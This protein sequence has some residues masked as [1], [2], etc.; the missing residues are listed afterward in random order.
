MEHSAEQVHQWV[1]WDEEPPIS[2]D[3]D[4]PHHFVRGAELYYQQ[5]TIAKLGHFLLKEKSPLPVEDYPL[6]KFAS[7]K[8]EDELDLDVLKR[9]IHLLVYHKY[10]QGVDHVRQYPLTE[11]ERKVLEK[12]EILNSMIIDNETLYREYT[13]DE[14]ES[15]RNYS[16][17]LDVMAHDNEKVTKL[18]AKAYL[19]EL[20]ET[21]KKVLAPLLVKFGSFVKI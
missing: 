8:Q 6:V 7:K 1:M 20:N 17:A 15:M 18:I 12:K 9:T 19:K 13:E 10:S 21:R 16:D 2:T 4:V 11:N 5:R 14:R 3:S